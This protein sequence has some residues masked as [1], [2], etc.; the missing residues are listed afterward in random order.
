MGRVIKD[1]PSRCAFIATKD[2]YASASDVNDDLALAANIDADSS[3]GDQGKDAIH[4][5]SVAASTGYP[6][7]LVQRV[8]SSRVGHEEEMQIQHHNLFH[9]Y[10]IVQVVMFSPSLIAGVTATW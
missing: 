3:K 10:L 8:L 4:I 5:D 2:G 1:C 6:S 7:L 9:M